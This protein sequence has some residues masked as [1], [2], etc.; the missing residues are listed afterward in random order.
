MKKIL[1]VFCAAIILFAVFAI[2]VAAV[3]TGIYDPAGETSDGKRVRVILLIA[4]S[5]A[6]A[7]LIIFMI[8]KN[9]RESK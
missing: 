7:A 2:T 6:A 3:E 1:C 9:F 8:I 4:V 5:A